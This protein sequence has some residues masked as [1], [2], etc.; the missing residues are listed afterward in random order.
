MLKH[1]VCGAHPALRAD[2]SP[3]E[4]GEVKKAGRGEENYFA[5]GTM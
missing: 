5:G 2:L 3:Q 4:R 1:N